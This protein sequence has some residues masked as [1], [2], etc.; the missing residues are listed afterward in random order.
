[1][2]NLNDYIKN[3]LIKEE[4]STNYMKLSL[5]GIDGGA[6]VVSSIKS[7][8]A[9]GSPNVYYT[10]GDDTSVIKIDVQKDNVSKIEKIIEL[11]QEFISSIPDDKHE[12]IAS[13]LDKLSGELE[14]IQDKVDSF[15]DE[16]SKDDK[17]DEKLDDEK[18][19]KE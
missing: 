7:I 14:K 9:N 6:D 16:D 19:E 5:S 2:I 17:D 1:M 8:C 11:V 3:S 18:S 13:Q 12:N 4:K 15:S 10:L